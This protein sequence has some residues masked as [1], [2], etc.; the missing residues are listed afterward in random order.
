[1]NSNKIEEALNAL[2]REDSPLRAE[3]LARLATE[4]YYADEPEGTQ[5][6][7]AEAV[8]MAE[9]VGDPGI[10]AYVLTALHFVRQ[11]PEVHPSQ[12]LPIEA[13]ILNS[14]A[15]VFFLNSL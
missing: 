15:N 13:A 1:M 5:A 14:L 8:A 2:P 6:M 7:A 10:L 4:S 9:R 12:R 3:V 11:L